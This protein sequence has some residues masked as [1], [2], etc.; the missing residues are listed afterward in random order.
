MEGR[1]QTTGRIGYSVEAGPSAR[2]LEV[3]PKSPKPTPPTKLLREWPLPTAATL[4]SSVR[5]KG[6]LL[7]VRAHLPAC[8]RKLVDVTVGTVV[9]RVPEEDPSDHAA[10]IEAI[11]RTLCRVEEL[12]VI[13]REIEDILTITSTERHRWLK[14]GRL[15]SA[16]TRTVKLRGRARKITFH[17]FDPRHV[18]DI[19]DRDMPSLWREQDALTAAENRRRA[20]GQAALTRVAKRDKSATPTESRAAANLAGE[21]LSGWEEFELNG[22]LR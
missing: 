22:L 2:H 13:P 3:M 4:G 8:E 11:S 10:T 16:G 7:E 20:A 15:K 17:V 19:L 5:A 6:I 9:L 1:A 18:E 21:Q 14:D 12:P